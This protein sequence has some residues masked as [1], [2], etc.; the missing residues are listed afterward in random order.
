M[1]SCPMTNQWTRTS[2]GT[3]LEVERPPE[4]GEEEPVDGPAEGAAVADVELV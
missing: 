1:Q 2:E 3:L 4:P